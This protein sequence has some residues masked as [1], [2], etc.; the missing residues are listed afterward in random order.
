[1]GN[2]W[3]HI[4]NPEAMAMATRWLTESEKTLFER[5]V[6]SQGTQNLYPTFD[7]LAE[8]MNIDQFLEYSS[9]LDPKRVPKT[10]KQQRYKKALKMTLL[11]YAEAEVMITKRTEE[12]R[13]CL[14]RAENA[15]AD[16][17]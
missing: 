9:K 7:E 8:K 6:V 10:F 13:D 3:K 15:L 5:L 12:L 2:H 1:M 16:A 14:R 17:S 4:V 11:T